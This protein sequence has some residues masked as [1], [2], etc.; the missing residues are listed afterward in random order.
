MVIFQL[1][2]ILLSIVLT[3]FRFI[4]WTPAEWYKSFLSLGKN[5]LFMS[6]KCIAGGGR[7]TAANAIIAV[8]AFSVELTMNLQYVAVM[9]ALGVSAFTIWVAT[10]NFMAVANSGH[11]TTI[12]LRAKYVELVDLAQAINCMWSGLCF[13]F[14]LYS[15]IWMSV[16][17]DAIL[18]SQSYVKKTCDIIE[19]ICLFTTFVFS[20][21]SSRNVSEQKYFHH[22]FLVL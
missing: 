9:S 6:N 17:L 7:E 4:N 21:Q 16:D 10:S 13:W 3:T 20:A 15:S 22:D 11:L 2:W 1:G 19:L 12:Q 18:K 5:M 8:F 14:I